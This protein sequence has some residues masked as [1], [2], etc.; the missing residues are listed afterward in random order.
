MFRL[1][2]RYTDWATLAAIQDHTTGQELAVRIPLDTPQGHARY[3][4]GWFN[5]VT[6]W[7]TGSTRTVSGVLSETV[8]GIA[9]PCV[10]AVFHGAQLGNTVT[11][12]TPNN[13]SA[14]GVRFACGSDGEAQELMAD[15]F[16][17]ILNHDYETGT[18][19][20]NLQLWG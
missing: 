15:Y 17:I 20:V 13:N 12:N 16:G 4:T 5:V 2:K 9:L 7:A 3:V 19:A 18:L 11:L 10:S 6:V 1:L 14:T 8:D